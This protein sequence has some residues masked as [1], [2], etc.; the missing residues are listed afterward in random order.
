MTK[1]NVKTGEKV[2][3]KRAAPSA[4]ADPAAGEDHLPPATVEELGR[5]IEK[6]LPPVLRPWNEFVKR[7]SKSKP[8]NSGEVHAKAMSDAWQHLPA[9]ER[10]KFRQAYHDSKVRR[11]EAVKALSAEDRRHWR[12]YSRALRLKRKERQ[13]T[14]RPT[15]YM[16]Y[17]LK[18]HREIRRD[19]PSML[20]GAV[21]KQVADEWCKMSAEA[22]RAYE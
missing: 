6:S 3:R 14:R 9:D 11:E 5:R 19:N 10:E 2:S 18:R 15:G 13:S 12:L 16:V 4:N 20:F 8:H 21:S 7:E 22:R 17:N 1:T